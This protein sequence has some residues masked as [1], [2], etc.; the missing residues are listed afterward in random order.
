M[1]LDWQ[2]VKKIYLLLM[3]YWSKS[4]MDS[5]R[6]EKK[7]SF[8][9]LCFAIPIVFL[10][11]FNIH[12]SIWHHNFEKLKNLWICF[13]NLVCIMLVFRHN[14]ELLFKFFSRSFVKINNIR[15]RFFITSTQIIHKRV[16]K[17]LKSKYDIFCLNT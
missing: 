5:T 10:T 1:A 14:F 3:S 2:K 13:C 7:T 6:L 17:T 8:L 16:R 12:I 9:P 11:K 15:E 4:I